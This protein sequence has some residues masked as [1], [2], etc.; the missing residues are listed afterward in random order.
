MLVA[1]LA[2]GTPLS[3]QRVFASGIGWVDFLE[4][5]SGCGS[6]TAAV[7]SRGL[8]APDGIDW[9]RSQE[10]ADWAW[11]L[12][13]PECQSR[14]AA[15]LE[16]IQPWILHFAPPCTVFSPANQHP[17]APGS[18]KYEEAMGHVRLSLFWMAEWRKRGRGAS[19]ESES[20]LCLTMQIPKWSEQRSFS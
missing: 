18:A 3:L 1:W 14:L 16:V 7:R 13:D 12:R 17:A 10:G 19:L 9:D 15:L 6:L 20:W 2:Q 4:I 11:D 8:V 5:F